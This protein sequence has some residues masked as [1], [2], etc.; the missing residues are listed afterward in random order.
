MPCFPIRSCE[1][2]PTWRGSSPRWPWESR[3][4]SPRAGLA[5]LLAAPMTLLMGGTLTVLIR[6]LV[7]S[8]LTVSGWTIALLY[9]V[10]T[11]G[12]AAGAFLTHFAFVPVA[13][14]FATQMVAVSLNVC[15]AAG[16]LWLA[17]RRPA[18]PEVQPET[19]REPK[20]SKHEKRQKRPTVAPAR[21][22][23]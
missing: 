11:V 3:S 14:L 2:M 21:S 7:R 9:G 18:A 15:A 12:A 23:L 5:I 8:D 22:P 19:P 13:G 1:P 17:A 20:T 4:S 10:N 6:Y 16:A